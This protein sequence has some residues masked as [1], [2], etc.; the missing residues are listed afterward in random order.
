MKPNQTI[1][2]RKPQFATRGGFAQPQ[3]SKRAAYFKS[4]RNVKASADAAM[5]R[6]T[7][8][9]GKDAK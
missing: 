2:D 5:A 4:Y 9:R 6:L 3:A 8:T 7:A 1:F